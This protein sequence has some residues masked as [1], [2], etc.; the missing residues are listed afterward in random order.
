MGSVSVET[1]VEDTAD[2]QL[3]L[4]IK[5]VGGGSRAALAGLA[6]I[7]KPNQL[8]SSFT[9]A[10]LEPKWRQGECLLRVLQASESYLRALLLVGKV[11]VFAETFDSPLSQ[12]SGGTLPF[13][14]PLCL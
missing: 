11:A 3:K 14:L 13:L 1:E 12:L 4:A 9:P 7:A 8:Q 5:V 6:E 10:N 2:N